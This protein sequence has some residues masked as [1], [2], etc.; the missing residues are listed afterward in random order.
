MVRFFEKYSNIKFQDNLYR[1]GLNYSMRTDGGTDRQHGLTV[2][3]LSLA[4]ATK[5]HDVAIYLRHK[6]E[7]I[8]R[9]RAAFF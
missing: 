2:A 9:Q 1:E 3:F 5:N 7:N 8:L 4:N 6:S